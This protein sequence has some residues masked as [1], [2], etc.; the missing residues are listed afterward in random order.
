MGEMGEQEMGYV[1]ERDGVLYVRGS[2]VPLE[3]L[4]RL[5]M[6]PSRRDTRPSINGWPR[7]A[8]RAAS[9]ASA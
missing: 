5:L 1:E 2:R 8:R 4:V 7:R 6:P 3:S 9:P